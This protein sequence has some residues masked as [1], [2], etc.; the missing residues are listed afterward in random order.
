[1]DIYQWNYLNWGGLTNGWDLWVCTS[2]GY[3]VWD[4]WT[5]NSPRLCRFSWWSTSFPI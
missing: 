5:K 4:P 2:N 3:Q 1:M